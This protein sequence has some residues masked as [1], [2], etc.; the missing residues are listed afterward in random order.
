MSS[1]AGRRR[2]PAYQEYGSDLLSIE[3]VRLMSLAE[4]GLLA[5]MRWHVWANDSMPREPAALA[6]VLGLDPGEVKDALTERVLRLFAPLPADA[7]RLYC[8]E[9]AAQMQRLRERALERAE[10]GRRGGT[11]PRRGKSRVP[12][13]ARSSGKAQLE[14]P[15][16]LPEKSRDEK[17]RGEL[18]K[19]GDYSVVDF[20]RDYDSES[21]E[22]ALR[23]HPGRQSL[24]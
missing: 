24:S 22:G 5:T 18:G 6:R 2:P 9:L 14:A 16:K 21:L 12:S 3:A 11:S 19:G 23:A 17:S 1:D 15:V 4:R 13:S 10:S 20:V 7:T 8:P